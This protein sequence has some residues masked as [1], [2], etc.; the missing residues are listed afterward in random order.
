MY[1]SDANIVLNS[2]LEIFLRGLKRGLRA[3]DLTLRLT[4]PQSSNRSVIKFKEGSVW[5][6]V[7]IRAVN[8]FLEISS[9]GGLKNILKS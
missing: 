9:V 5:K 8:N 3:E 7:G 6:S 4:D 1:I 2:V